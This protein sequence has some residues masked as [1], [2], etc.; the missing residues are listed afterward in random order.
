M[1][2]G[3]SPEQSFQSGKI[4]ALPEWFSSVLRFVAFECKI[5]KRTIAWIGGRRGFRRRVFLLFSL[6]LYSY[7]SKTRHIADRW[8]TT[9]RHFTDKLIN[10]MTPI[11]CSLAIYAVLV[12]RQIVDRCPTDQHHVI[13]MLSGD[14]PSLEPTDLLQVIE[15]SLYCA[16]GN[17]P[18]KGMESWSRSRAN[19]RR[20]RPSVANDEIGF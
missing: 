8:R 3:L 16:L 20:E 4:F 18:A 13:A 15:D 7:F 9:P 5:N 19:S 1:L 17:P 14:F 6:T 2:R 10:R 11:R 12:P